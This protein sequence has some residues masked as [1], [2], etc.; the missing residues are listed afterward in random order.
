MAKRGRSRG[1]GAEAGRESEMERGMLD[2][3]EMS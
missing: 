3:I 2:R 1:L